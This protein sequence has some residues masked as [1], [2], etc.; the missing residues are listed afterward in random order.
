MSLPS[1][2]AAR[3]RPPSW[4]DGR[5]LLGILLVLA[6][7]VLGARVLAAADRTER[8]YATTQ[9]L[10]SGTT[11][12]ADDVRA[13]RVR[14]FSGA[15]RYLDG[16][17]PKPVGYVLARAVGAGELLPRA[18]LDNGALAA[19]IVA[20]PVSP[21]HFP[22][23]LGHGDKVDVYRTPRARPGGPAGRPS[24]VLAAATVEDVNDTRTGRLSAG[25]DAG[26]LLRVP[27]DRVVGLVDA[28]QGG[29]IDLVRVP[30]GAEVVL[31]PSGAAR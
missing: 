2:R 14:L 18:A 13:V 28:I 12:E 30:P 11:L 6:S 29:S 25:G 22:A 3:L 23:G 26:V 8:V 7:V 31:T 10:A 19:R 4:L 15:Q 17:G 5:L 21:H 24:L 1:P 16:D 20:V 27:P 9:D